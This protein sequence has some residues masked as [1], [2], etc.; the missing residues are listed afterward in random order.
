MFSYTYEAFWRESSSTP[1]NKITHSAPITWNQVTTP[2][3]GGSGFLGGQ[4]PTTRYLFDFR[5]FQGGRV[6]SQ[7]TWDL[8]GPMRYVNL[9]GWTGGGP[10]PCAPGEFRQ[11]RVR[12][13]D[14]V[15]FSITTGCDV[16]GFIFNVRP[17]W[18]GA[19]NCGNSPD[20]SPPSSGGCTTTFNTGLVIARPTCI[21]VVNSI[22]E[23]PCC[24]PMLPKVNSILA[25]L[26]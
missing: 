4:C 7:G 26:Q 12:G 2:A 25:R 13:G 8:M 3:S 19:N 9:S 23:C 21:Q 5:G 24:K 11:I 22:P 16:S 18:G 15:I 14:G 20:Y 6:V 10:N 17:L 1:W